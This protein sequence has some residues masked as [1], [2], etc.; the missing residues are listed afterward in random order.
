LNSKERETPP[1]VKAPGEVGSELNVRG[2]KEIPWKG[3]LGTA[4]PRKGASRPEKET[5]G[6]LKTEREENPKRDLPR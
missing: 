1:I 5:W 3:E 6:E 4:R 2:I